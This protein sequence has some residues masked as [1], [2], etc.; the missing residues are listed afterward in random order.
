[1]GAYRWIAGWYDLVLEPLLASSKARGRALFTPAAGSLVLDVGCGTGAQLARYRGCGCRLVGVDPSPAMVAQARRS[2]GPD[3][4]IHQADASALP[5]DSG[6]VGLA[7]CSMALHEMGGATR[8]AVLREIRRVLAPDAR[9]LVLDYHLGRRPGWRGRVIWWGIV[10]AERLAGGDHYRHFRQF[11][12]AGGLQTFAA[13][14]GLE[15]ETVQ[16]LKAGNL[17]LYLL[18]PPVSEPAAGVVR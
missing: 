16:P 15:I 13:R 12:A 11:M 8:E 9:L 1:M 5:L 3:A 14:A 10:V 7:L 4:E 6:S 18:R 17:A 2:L